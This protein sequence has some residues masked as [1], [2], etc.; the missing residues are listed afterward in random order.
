MTL[1][2]S[3]PVSLPRSKVAEVEREL[4]QFK[5]KY[6]LLLSDRFKI[7]IPSELAVLMSPVLCGREPV[8][9]IPH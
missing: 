3:L 4:M 7:T 6:V 5:A 9:V 2:Q 8:L 1:P